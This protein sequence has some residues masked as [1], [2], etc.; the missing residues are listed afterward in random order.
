M[1]NVWDSQGV[2]EEKEISHDKE[3]LKAA[4]VMVQKI[5]AVTAEDM[6]LP[7]SDRR[8]HVETRSRILRRKI[9]MANL[10]L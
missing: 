3:T 8:V 9:E 2:C 1:G 7:L 6:D 10:Q 4:Q 5:L